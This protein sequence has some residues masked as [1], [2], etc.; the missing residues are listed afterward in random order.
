ASASNVFDTAIRVTEL[1]S[2]RASS[3][4][5]AISCSTDASPLGKGGVVGEDCSGAIW[6][7]GGEFTES[8]E[9]YA[10]RE[11]LLE[12]FPLSCARGRGTDV[13]LHFQSQASQT[14]EASWDS[15]PT[16]F[17]GVD[18]GGA[19]DAGTRALARGCPRLADRASLPG[20]FQPRSA[21]RRY[22]ARSDFIG[23]DHAE[24]SRLYPRFG[25]RHGP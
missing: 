8:F 16:R 9:F 24:I 17:A 15:R 3:Q 18:P 22:T 20:F 1:R 4:A 6:S 25:G 12:P 19:A 5:R 7:S 10:V 2:R 21:Q 14:Q 13:A 11:R 23:R